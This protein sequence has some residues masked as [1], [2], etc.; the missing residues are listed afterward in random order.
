M[1]DC[2]APKRSL[3]ARAD[4][5]CLV[6]FLPPAFLIATEKP[7]CSFPR[8]QNQKVREA[9]IRSAPTSPSSDPGTTCSLSALPLA[10]P[11][12]AMRQVRHQGFTTERSAQLCAFPVNEPSMVPS[13]LPNLKERGKVFENYILNF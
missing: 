8:T 12:G 6:P 2:S 11:P 7:R 5:R 13:P 4:S 1:V 10:L 9:L 3:D